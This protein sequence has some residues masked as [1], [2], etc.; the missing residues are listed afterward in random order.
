VL[1]IDLKELERGVRV[2]MRIDFSGVEEFVPVGEGRYLAEVVDSAEGLSNRSN[3][4][5]W[6]LSLR[7]LQQQD[8]DDEFVGKTIKWDIS[9]Q[10]KALWK[11][12]QTL[13]ALGEDVTKEDAEYDF[14]SENYKGRRVTMIVTKRNDP[15][16]GERTQV[17]RLE[18]ATA[19]SATPEAALA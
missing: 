8:G 10:P 19:F 16:Y 13:Q 15:T 17:S 4:R 12:M 1:T 2:K 3:Q 9:L 11:V 14:D 5:K 18:M 6:S 7:V